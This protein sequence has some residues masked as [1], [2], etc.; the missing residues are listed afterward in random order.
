[1]PIPVLMPALSPTMEEGTLSKWLVKEGDKIASGDLIAEIE[2]DKATM[3]VEA[4][5][6]GVMGRILVPAGTEGV[7]VNT[8]IALILEEG[9]DKGA[10]AGTGKPAPV[11]KKAKPE[12]KPTA[13]AKSAAPPP[14]SVAQAAS[15]K[16]QSIHAVSDERIKASPLAKRLAAQSG[17]DLTALKGSGP[18]GRI[19]KRDI[20]AAAGGRVGLAAQV[21]P[22]KSPAARPPQDYGIRPG[23]YDEV[24]LDTLRKVV[25]QRM[26]ES[27][28]TVPHFPLT[29]DCEIDKLM[30]LRR[31]LNAKS[32]DGDGAF[33]LS[34]NDFVI[35]ASALA[36]KKIPDVNASFAG[37]KRLLHHHA[38]IAVAV[39]LE[40]GLI[41]PIIW[42]AENKGLEE[43]SR[44]MKDKAERARKR[45]LMPE[46]YQG[47]TF[48]VSNLGMYGVKEFYAV[49]N[50]PH[51]AI[52][53]VGMGEKRPVVKDDALA[54]ATVMSCTLSCDH[55]VVDGALGARW[56]QVFKG[57]VEDPVT[58]LL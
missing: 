52:L 29:V 56:L 3:E 9:E 46:E 22:F 53:A 5:D 6:D 12:A 30:A 45:K 17:L 50:P 34:V 21:I 42:Q 33:K 1:M 4:T 24:P 27:K 13:P 47:G 58:M 57:Y 35:R 18:H 15:T 31:E 32:P 36:L 37:D 38:D 40:G 16:V 26:T 39:A 2:T 10:L 41:T 54:I 43:I 11:A 25:A 48:S 23:T 19:I 28:Q 8:E 44:E 55:R 49:I 7:K 14:R 20:E 51:G